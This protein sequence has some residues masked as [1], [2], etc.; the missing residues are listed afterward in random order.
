MAQSRRTD[1]PS[2]GQGSSIL[3]AL[4]ED[5]VLKVISGSH[6]SMEGI[7]QSETEENEFYD[8]EIPKHHFLVFSSGLHHFL[9]NS[10]VSIGNPANEHS[11]KHK[12][13][14][15]R[16]KQVLEENRGRDHV[17]KRGIC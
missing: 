3:I 6:R 7:Y 16:E 17:V 11:V 14:D 15:I 12:R 8:V 10:L 4:H 13:T 1:Q 5:F 2:P 9:H